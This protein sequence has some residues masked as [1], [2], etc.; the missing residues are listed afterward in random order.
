[1]SASLTPFEEYRLYVERACAVLDVSQDAVQHFLE[2][3]EIIRKKLSVI[4]DEI[5]EELPAYRVQFN[6]ARGPYKGGIRFHPEAN[7]SEVTALAGTMAIKCAVVNIPLGGGKGGVQVDPKLLTHDEVHEVSR[8][9]VREMYDYIGPDKDIPAPDVYTN[10]EIMAIMLDEFEKIKGEPAPAAFTG[11]PLER[12]GIAGR[13]TATA[14][15]GVSVLEQY[16]AQ[17]GLNPKELRVAVHGFGNAGQVA[18]ELLQEKGYTIVGVADSKG[19]V[20]NQ[21]GLDVAALCKLKKEGKELTSPYVKDGDVDEEAVGKDGVTIGGSDA[22]LVMDADILI[23]AAL[24][25]V[26]TKDIVNNIDVKII[27]ELA[28]GPTTA[29]ADLELHGRGVAIIPDA[30]ANAGGVYVSYLE[31]LVGKTGDTMTRDEVNTKL[32]DAMKVAWS[33]VSKFA[34]EHDV[35]YRTAAFALG[36]SRILEAEENQKK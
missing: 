17:E 13:D 27:L 5:P 18:A 3:N 11:K 9:F 10:A 35:S 23:P 15:G 33:D 21:Q 2:P 20:M 1:M 28:N 16:V 36:I 14:Y 34:E 30:L 19:S 4:I 26:L 25:G 22:V 29:E 32:Q 6:N 31:W 12:G 8:A 7:E 24:D